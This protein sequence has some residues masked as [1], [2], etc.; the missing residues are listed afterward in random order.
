M[1]QMKC[2]HCESEKLAQA[3][4]PKGVV[5]VMPCPACSG[6][7]VRFR[8]KAIA[9]DRDVLFQGSKEE[10]KLHLADVI[11]EFMDEDVLQ[12]EM[13]QGEEEPQ[14]Q[15]TESEGQV[16]IEASENDLPPITEAELSKFVN[17]D[18]EN[19]DNLGYF[20]KHLE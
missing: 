1:S 9:L 10:R 7:V 12:F 13:L 19:L 4:V 8:H 16:E 6:L 18:L 5:A 14:D 15:Q 11:A 3:R 17:V 2:P 20:K